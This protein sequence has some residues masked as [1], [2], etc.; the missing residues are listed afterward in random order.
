MTEQK[1][2]QLELGFS[3]QGSVRT[4]QR[5]AH[6]EARESADHLDLGY[7]RL[8]QLYELGK[9][10][11]AAEGTVSGPDALCC[12][13]QTVPLRVAMLVETTGGAAH[14]VAVRAAGVDD[15]EVEA[16]AAHAR[17]CVARLAGVAS[18]EQG[19]LR[20]EDVTLPVAP[21]PG[22]AGRSPFAAVPLVL[23]RRTVRGALY[24]RGAKALGEADLAFLSAAADQISLAWDRHAAWQREVQL[25]ERAEA[26]DKAQKELVAVVSH[27]LRNPLGA[28]LLGISTLRR[29]PQL[30]AGKVRES[31]ESMQRAAE[32]AS[33]LVHDLLDVARLDAGRLQLDLAH[34]EMAAMVR[35]AAELMR[36]LLADRGLA[37]E[38]QIEEGLPPVLADR[39]RVL[40]VLSNLIGNARKFARDGSTVSV[41]AWQQE[42][43]ARCCVSDEGAGIAPQDLPHVFDRYFQGE[44]GP[45]AHGAG[46][47]LAIARGI[48]EAH[49]GRI[50]VES[51]QGRGSRFFFTLPLAP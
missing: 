24:V 35:E 14:I 27:D 12:L 17:T 6:R 11:G 7:A 41:A 37:C 29:W 10:L 45:T 31:L 18:L 8:R 26:L 49:G 48:V 28:V 42:G 20:V 36:P 25:R 50:W 43:E 16:A 32:R 34:E 22:A 47:G 30:D 3:A 1:R 19:R 46:L 2:R 23:E 5:A 9:I 13:G 39:E 40:Q 44:H 33:K 51:D 15:G 21:R 38:A 4:A